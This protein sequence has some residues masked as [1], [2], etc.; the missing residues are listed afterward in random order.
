M[1]GTRGNDNS[2][3]GNIG[4]MVIV[5]PDSPATNSAS[6][7]APL[8]PHDQLKQDAE[9]AI[10]LNE[11]FNILFS[12]IA[13]LF[14]IPLWNHEGDDN[15][16]KVCY[17]FVG[18]VVG[19]IV[20]VGWFLPRKKMR[21]WW[22]N[23]IIPDKL[24]PWS[25]RFKTM[26]VVGL[27]IGD[28]VGNLIPIPTFL[29]GGQISHKVLAAFIG[30]GVG[31]IL[32]LTGL[33]FFKIDFLAHFKKKNWE[34][35]FKK[36]FEFGTDGDGW[37]KYAKMTTV[38]S[39]NFGTIIGAFLGFFY[40]SPAVG[41][42]VGGA[43]GALAGCLSGLIIIPLG[44]VIKYKILKK[45]YKPNA[46]QPCNDQT[47]ETEKKPFLERCFSRYRTNHIR[48]GAALGGAL[49]GIVG[50]L[51][52]AFLFPVF[53]PL[54]GAAVGNAIGALLGGVIFGV[55]GPM[56][57]EQF[58]Y[59]SDIDT[60]NSPDYALRTA[61]MLGSKQGIG[62]AVSSK[63][64]SDYQPIVPEA[65]SVTAG[66]LGVGREFFYRQYIKFR[67]KKTNTKLSEAYVKDYILPWTQRMATG[68]VIGSAVGSFVGLLA[69][70]GLGVPV[71]SAIGAVVG[72]VAA[73]IIEGVCR[74][75]GWIPKPAP[76]ATT[77]A[78][79]AATTSEEKPRSELGSAL[80]NPVTASPIFQSRETSSQ[81][82][83]YPDSPLNSK[84][85]LPPLQKSSDD[86]PHSTHYTANE[87]LTNTSPKPQPLK[88][89]SNSF[90][91]PNKQKSNDDPSTPLNSPTKTKRD[92]SKSATRSF[93]S[94][95]VV[96]DLKPPFNDLPSDRRQ[97]IVVGNS[98]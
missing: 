36:Y 67:A 2:N 37:S 64:S 12:S 28:I 82:D 24:N 17:N 65:A 4:A 7:T 9:I 97:E 51:L 66:L 77:D 14:M 85:G 16:V 53:G 62:P 38:W 30:Y 31:L 1:T 48:A 29:P 90:H 22:R 72:A 69:F 44:N 75:L 68:I 42:A 80:K 60:G 83:E 73:V 58:F 92:R 25:R 55:L 11:L 86:I 5:D 8:T 52:G 32:G 33:V 10:R 15:F 91:Q 46:A 74:K 19:V 26:F 87:H 88:K 94:Q 54:A 27:K 93:F 40:F 6:S 39:A 23:S 21:D 56:I 61:A 98:G 35:T 79:Q 89:R 71:G 13:A 41:I 57:N 3:F 18:A 84:V 49:G 70:P 96:S 63:F 45:E 59:A 76:K 47:T 34:S 50:A 95:N 43:I 78:M 81:E 20:A